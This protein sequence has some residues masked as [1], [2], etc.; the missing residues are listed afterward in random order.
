MV[1]ST[2]E[3]LKPLSIPPHI[4]TQK[5]KEGPYLYESGVYYGHYKANKRNGW[6]TFVFNDGCLYEGSWE[7]DMMS[8]YGRLI[9][10]NCVYEQIS[11]FFS[12]Q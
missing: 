5:S 6:G 3:K 4:D 12:F 9:K 11:T 2:Q 1:K 7:N 10:N 8:G